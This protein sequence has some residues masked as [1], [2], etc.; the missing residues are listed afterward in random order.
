[1]EREVLW[2]HGVKGI[3]FGEL[4]VLWKIVSVGPEFQ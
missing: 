2:E 1:M 4:N 3:E